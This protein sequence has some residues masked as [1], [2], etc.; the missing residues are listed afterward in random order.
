MEISLARAILED[1]VITPDGLRSIVAP[2]ARERTR[3]LMARPG[4]ALEGTHSVEVRDDYPGVAIIHVKG[5]LVRYNGWWGG[6]S[7]G[8]ILKDLQ[9][10]LD[11]PEVL[12]IAWNFDSPGGE[13]NSCAE[14]S[15]AI[16]K[17][18][19]KKPM[20]AYASYLCASGALWLASAVGNIQCAATAI[21]GSIGVITYL[22]DDT[23]LMSDLGVKE[24][25][26][27]ASQSPKKSQQPKDAGYRGRVQQRIDDTAAVFIDA[28]A[29][30]YGV[31]ASY[32]LANFG[33]GDVFV[34]EKA[35]A[36]GLATKISNFEA[37]LAG[38][39][40]KASPITGPVP[41]TPTLPFLGVDHM[42]GKMIAKL[43]R[44]D[45]GAS[46]RQIEDRA[47][48]L[49]QFERSVLASTDSKSA[50]EAFGKVVAGA[51]AIAER[52]QLRAQLKEQEAGIVQREFRSEVKSAM[53]DGR[54][55]LGELPIVTSFMKDEER[56]KADAALAA[57]KSQE[58][59]ELLDA[60]CQG[61]VSAKRLVTLKAFLSKKSKV[62]LPKPK[63]EVADTREG[64][65][66]AAREQASPEQVKAFVGSYGVRPEAVPFAEVGNV[67]ELEQKLEKKGA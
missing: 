29:R 37:V 26:I 38:L 28:V 31:T 40:K 15:D 42:D 55:T 12:A 64:R 8:E 51:S 53:K 32:V 13:V 44:L 27:V 3:A 41:T 33:E 47:Q 46:E 66:K 24:F 48:A 17:A 39:A 22:Y 30:N 58:R 60:L 11:N 6:T 57:C 10:C 65:D 18:R 45:D 67:E 56:D 21:L 1:W 4:K 20:A 19:G 25:E 34:G 63:A 9:R 61:T 5:A 16:Y 54:L 50:D 36:A 59:K 23:K 43:L 35:V 7:Y 49:V 52:D 62:D 2:D 14:C